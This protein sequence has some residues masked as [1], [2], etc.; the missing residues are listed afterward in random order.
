MCP[1]WYIREVLA[2]LVVL[3]S[4][5]NLHALTTVRLNGVTSRNPF[6][7]PGVHSSR[8]YGKQAVDRRPFAVQRA[9][10]ERTSSVAH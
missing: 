9:T 6:L 10:I 5:R 7:C 4:L 1:F 8:N 2:F 3:S